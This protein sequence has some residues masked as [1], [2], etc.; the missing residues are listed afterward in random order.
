[1]DFEGILIFHS[2][3][4]REEILGFYERRFWGELGD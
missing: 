2:G 1:M 3:F 4:L